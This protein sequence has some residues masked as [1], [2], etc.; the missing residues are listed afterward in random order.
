MTA[1]CIIVKSENDELNSQ[2]VCQQAQGI[3]HSYTQPHSV[4]LSKVHS[5]IASSPQAEYGKSLFF[6]NIIAFLTD[7]VP[8]NEP[9]VPR[10]CA[11][12]ACAMRPSFREFCF[13]C[14]RKHS[15][16]ETGF[17]MNFLPIKGENSI[18][19]YRIVLTFKL[20]K[21]R[22]L[23]KEILVSEALDI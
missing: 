20:A 10:G 3:L 9:L 16:T 14:L 1:P 23:V 7:S 17:K 19:S 5:L 22:W 6:P 2:A 4:C 8:W 15:Q 13:C 21:I 18:T 11:P 12:A